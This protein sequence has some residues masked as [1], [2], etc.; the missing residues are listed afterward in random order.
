MNVEIIF[1]AIMA[2]L[3]GVSIGKSRISKSKRFKNLSIEY[4][5]DVWKP[6]VTVLANQETP[7]LDVSYL[8]KW[9]DVESSGNPCAIGEPVL[10]DGYPQEM[11]IMQVYNPDYISILNIDVPGI[12][13]YCG[14]GVS[15]G[16]T[17]ILTTDEMTYQVKLLIELLHYCQHNSNQYMMEASIQWG[18]QSKSYWKAVKLWHA[19]PSL[20]KAFPLVTQKLGRAPNDWTECI[21]TMNTF[22]PSYGGKIDNPTPQQ[23]K[24]YNRAWTAFNNADKCGEAFEGQSVV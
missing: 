4:T 23:V 17:R 21:S 13:A 20:V 24:A 15:S 22:G 14:P 3:L 5:T 1:L 16:V 6:L 10:V 9:I 11:G 19:L 7:P 8:Q 2:T 18:M 12:R